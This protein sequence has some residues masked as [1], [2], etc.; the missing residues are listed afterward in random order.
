M[1]LSN[2]PKKAPKT[3]LAKRMR[4]WMAARTGTKAERRFT[5]TQLCEALE[6][7]E[8]PMHQ[9]VA[10]AIYDFERRGELQHYNV[11]APAKYRRAEKVDQR[12]YLYITDWHAVLKGNINKKIYKAIYVSGDF[13]V[14]DIQRLTGLQDR[15]WLDRIVPK[16]RNGGHIQ[17]IN[18]RLC[19]HGAGAETV[20]HVVNRDKFKLEVMR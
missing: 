8:G 10:N 7:P 16:L 20:Y 2:T 1:T 14:T 5:I 4:A 15:D 13:T 12:H 11:K 3:T 18:K 19:G 6:I 9:K 17:Q